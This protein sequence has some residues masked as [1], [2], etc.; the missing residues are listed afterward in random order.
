MDWFNFLVYIVKS[1]RPDNK[2]FEH[3]PYREW[4]F[5]TEI[6]HLLKILLN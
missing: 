1:T 5:A 6:Q 2:Y 4:N 3:G